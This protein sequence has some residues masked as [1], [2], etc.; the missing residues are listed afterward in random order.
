MALQSQGSSP[1][2]LQ[3]GG[4]KSN[5]SYVLNGLR[6]AIICEV[7]AFLSRNRCR[8]CGLPT[9]RLTLAKAFGLNIGYSL[10]ERLHL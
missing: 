7:V 2:I 8:Y 10:M 1:R 9:R 5:F 3:T 6:T 4:T